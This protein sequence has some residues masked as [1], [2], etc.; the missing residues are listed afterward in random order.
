[1][2]NKNEKLNKGS[3]ALWKMELNQIKLQREFGG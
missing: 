3:E 1:M 2:K